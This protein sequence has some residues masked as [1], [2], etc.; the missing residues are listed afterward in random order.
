M[1]EIPPTLELILKEAKELEVKG[2]YSKADNRLSFVINEFKKGKYDNPNFL[3]DALNHGGIVKRMLMQYDDALENYKEALKLKPTNEQKAFANVNIADI[4]R[5]AKSNFKAAHE[6]LKKAR[7]C[8]KK[9]PYAKNRGI[10]HAKIEDQKGLVFLAQEEYNK[11]INSYQ[12]AIEICDDLMEHHPGDKEIENR[13][14][15]AVHHLGVAYIKLNDPKNV[16]EAYESQKSALNVFRELGDQ[17]GIVNSVSA[18]GEI[19]MIKNNPDESIKQYK[20]AWGILEK[21]GYDRAKIALALNLAEAYLTKKE[22]EKAIPY[23]K[24]FR[25]GIINKKITKHDINLMRDKYKKCMIL[26]NQ[27][28]ILADQMFMKNVY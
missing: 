4:C 18:L 12:G 9:I 19:A 13:F 20:E 22:P 11:A 8:A 25:D 7:S 23:L 26:A 3:A 24:Q 2:E 21:T 15:Q 6:H 1:F 17:Q 14:G 27:C 5:V 10:M 28:M 16:K